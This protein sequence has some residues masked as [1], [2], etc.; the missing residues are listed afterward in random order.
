MQLSRFVLPAVLTLG[1]AV[2]FVTPAVAQAHD[3]PRHE[4]RYHHRQRDEDF[5]VYYRG[6]ACQPWRLYGC[7]DDRP[8]ARCAAER[9]E[10]RG[11]FVRICR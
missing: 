2:P 9:L 10:H 4:G 6:D 11:F 8:D 7:F 1:S 3:A 5:R